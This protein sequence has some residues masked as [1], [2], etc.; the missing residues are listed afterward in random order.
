[1]QF[2]DVFT[3]YIEL[4]DDM[5]AVQEKIKVIDRENYQLRQAQNGNDM[6]ERMSMS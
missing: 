3:D 6:M 1:M 4:M 5:K 2:R